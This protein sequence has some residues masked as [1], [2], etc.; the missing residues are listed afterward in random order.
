MFILFQSEVS[1][2]IWSLWPMVQHPCDFVRITNDLHE[3]SVPQHCV[4]SCCCWLAASSR[5]VR[6]YILLCTTT[7]HSTLYTYYTLLYKLS[8]TD[9]P[10]VDL[11]VI[12]CCL[13]NHHWQNFWVIYNCVTKRQ[14]PYHV[15][16][17]TPIIPELKWKPF[18]WRMAWGIL[19][20]ES[21][22]N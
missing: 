16:V 2:H 4:C 14:L 5:R 1:I 8:S 6:I 15:C 20:L 22:G 7:L 9:P 10:T 21:K 11:L 12:V 13:K 18:P 3:P 17:T 19:R